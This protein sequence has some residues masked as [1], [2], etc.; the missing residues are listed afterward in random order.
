MAQNI[1]VGSLL[2]HLIAGFGGAKADAGRATMASSPRAELARAHDDA[3]GVVVV[4][5]ALMAS[6]AA[7]EQQYRN[8]RDAIEHIRPI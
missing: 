1:D 7:A 3:I 8:R 6:E 4:T 2:R 5:L